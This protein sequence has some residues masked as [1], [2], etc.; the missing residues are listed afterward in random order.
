MDGDVCDVGQDDADCL[1]NN[2][3]P[4]DIRDKEVY[5]YDCPIEEFRGHKHNKEVYVHIHKLLLLLNSPVNSSMVALSKSFDI[6][7]C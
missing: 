1:E 2:D 6:T 4:D 7:S 3:R 5:V